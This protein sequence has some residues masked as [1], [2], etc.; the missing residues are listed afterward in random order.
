MRRV[1][2]HPPGSFARRRAPAALASCHTTVKKRIGSEGPYLV[3][4]NQRLLAGGLG[5]LGFAV[6]LDERVPLSSRRIVDQH[7]PINA[8]EYKQTPGGRSHNP[9]TIDE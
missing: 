9:E 3:Y 7:R 6:P 1:E 2:G 5:R 4:R 8:L